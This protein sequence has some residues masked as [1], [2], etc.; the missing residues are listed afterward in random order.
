MPCS[1]SEALVGDV[2]CTAAGVLGPRKNATAA[3]IH[4][5]AIYLRGFLAGRFRS[6]DELDEG[7]FR[8]HGPRWQGK[9]LEH[10]QRL[11]DKVEELAGE[12]DCT[13]G[14]LVLA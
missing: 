6:R 12:K 9:A 7:D 11:A 5:S 4:R 3:P 10:N 1:R 14:Q 8:R 13:P 2:Q